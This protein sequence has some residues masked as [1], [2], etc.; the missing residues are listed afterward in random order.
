[1]NLAASQIVF[2]GRQTF[3]AK[4][5]SIPGRPDEEVTVTKPVSFIVKGLRSALK[6]D[7]VTE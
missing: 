4:D 5:E 6:T 3:T 1:M 7:D 2:H